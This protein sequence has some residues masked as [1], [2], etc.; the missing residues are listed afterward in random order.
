MCA[1]HDLTR[2]VMIDCS[3]DNSGKDHTKQAAIF[4]QI[5][6]TYRDGQTSILGVMIE[7]NLMPGK[8]SWAE[9]KTLARGVSITDSC[10]GWDETES[11]LLHA[12]EEVARAR[13]A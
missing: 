2:G 5:V 12:S 1:R 3:H 9:G 11:L 4:R 7:S 10:M 13:A 6:E 8:Q